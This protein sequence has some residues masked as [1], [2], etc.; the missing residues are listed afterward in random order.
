MLLLHGHTQ[1][2]P[3]LLFSPDGSRL[4]STSEN[5]IVRVWQFPGGGEA[6]V[7]TGPRINPVYAGLAFSPDNR[8]LASAAYGALWVWDL[9]RPDAQT[10][11]SLPLTGG[12]PTY[13]GVQALA[14]TPT[15][16][17][18]VASG[19]RW[20]GSGFWSRDRRIEALFRTWDVGTWDERPAADFE[21][22]SSTWRE[23]W[24][25]EPAG[26]T[27]ATPDNTSVAFW[28]MT[29]GR[30]LFRLEGKS[31]FGPGALA[32]S[33]D[34]KRFAVAR[35]RSVTV[36][37]VARRQVVSEWQNP[38]PKHVQGVAFSPD[39]RTLATVSNDTVARLWDADTGKEKTAFAWDIGPLTA[40]AFSPDGMRAAVSGRKG[41]ILVWDVE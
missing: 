6:L 41:D 13:Q 40:V 29:S 28:D 10:P 23:R 1:T 3:I 8:W 32:F 9:S 37:D 33:P 35:T 38:T 26:L 14:F 11:R 22:R 30:E 15:G 16:N 39:G 19:L 17:R 25:I 36:C 18:L 4:G 2:V 27:L 12:S 5:G 34:G 24:R 21:I 20:A 7:F 31:R